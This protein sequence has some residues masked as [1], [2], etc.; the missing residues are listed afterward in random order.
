MREREREHAHMS[1]R[2]AERKGD[3]EYK[4]GSGSELLAQSPTWGLNSGAT[5]SWPE[6]KSGVQPTEPLRCPGIL[7]FIDVIVN[8]IIVIFSNTY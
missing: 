3:T 8:G 4:A 2:G 6:L 5:R 7:F 1:K